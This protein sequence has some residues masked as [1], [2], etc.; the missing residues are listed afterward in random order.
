MNLKSRFFFTLTM[1][2]ATLVASSFYSSPTYAA[3]SSNTGTGG[4]LGYAG[5]LLG[6][7][8]LNNNGGTQINLGLDGGYKLAPTYGVGAY[9]AYSP[10]ATLATGDSAGLYTIAAEA[11]YFLND[12]LPGAHVGAKAGF[13]ISRYALA[14]GTSTSSVNLVFG[15]AV[16]YDYALGGGLSVGGEANFLYYTSSPSTNSFNLL[17]SLKYWF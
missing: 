9:L 12:I 7:G 6:V 4:T 16:A 5:A 15:P 11:N 8:F 10:S 2:S 14:A 1:I 3:V 13:G 17:G